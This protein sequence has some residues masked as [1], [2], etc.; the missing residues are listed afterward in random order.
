MN[1]NYQLKLREDG[2]KNIISTAIIDRKSR[3]KFMSIFSDLMLNQPKLQELEFESVLHAIIKLFTLGL[4]PDNGTAYIIPYG[5]KAQPII[6][7]KGYQELA[8]NSGLYEF[9]DC[10][11]IK[12]SDV[13]FYDPLTDTTHWK[14]RKLTLKQA[15]AREEEETI[16]YRAFAITKEKKII[17]MYMSIEK[18]KKWHEKYS[19]AYK[20]RHIK[21]NVFNNHA[22]A[23][24]KKVVMKRFL[25]GKIKTPIFQEAIKFDSA[26]IEG[27]K[28]VYID[29]PNGDDYIDYV[30]NQKPEG[31]EEIDEDGEKIIVHD[32]TGD[33][34]G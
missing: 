30:M 15:E 20:N 7:Y 33:I 3:D 25:K 21:G 29:N 5:T 26:I 13:D 8:M 18:I 6:G 11:A 12:D 24:D 22:E 23:M 4:G 10:V 28:P 19:S 17:D 2:I 9:F 1:N 31:K 27:G 14:E 32:L 16:G 34:Y